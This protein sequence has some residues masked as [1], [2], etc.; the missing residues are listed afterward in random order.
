VRLGRRPAF[1]LLLGA[2]CLALFAVTPGELRWVNVSMTSVAVFWGILL[3]LDEL[4]GR[5]RGGRGAGMR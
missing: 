3:G 5:G 4:L 2:V 1:F